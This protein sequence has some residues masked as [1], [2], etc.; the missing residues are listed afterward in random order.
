MLLATRDIENWRG[1]KPD[2]GLRRFAMNLTK[3]NSLPWKS[4]DTE[5]MNKSMTICLLAAT[6][7]V[8]LP[9]SFVH[10]QNTV[11]NAPSGAGATTIY[12]QVMP[13]GR[14]V[15][16]DTVT[17]GVKIDRVLTVPGSPSQAA[18]K[19]SSDARLR[20]ASN[21]GDTK[22]SAPADR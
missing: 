7:I 1:L 6:P 4:A 14:V 3:R 17:K 21:A 22:S 18:G 2:K 16:S 8:F 10:A 13:N 11:A 20:G 12:R 19:P 5:A 15:Y 9:A